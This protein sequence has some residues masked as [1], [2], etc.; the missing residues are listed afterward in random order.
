M[1]IS[2]SSFNKVTAKDWPRPIFYTALRSHEDCKDPRSCEQ[3]RPTCGSLLTESITPRA[4]TGQCSLWNL[5]PVKRP[6]LFQSVP[7]DA[8]I[9]NIPV[10]KSACGNL[11][12]T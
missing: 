3:P 7:A 11:G 8:L 12:Y 2:V 5:I 1:D 4:T 9:G 10:Q 6:A